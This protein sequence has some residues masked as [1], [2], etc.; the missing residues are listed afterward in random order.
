MLEPSLSS[1]DRRTD[2]LVTAPEAAV[3]IDAMAEIFL[4]LKSQEC[5]P[6]TAV[7]DYCTDQAQSA[8]VRP[9][10]VSSLAAST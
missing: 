10:V 4:E 7:L 2:W 8:V 9:A 3:S 6:L 1:P 5:L